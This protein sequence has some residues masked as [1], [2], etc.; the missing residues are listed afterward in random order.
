ME[1]II[2]HCGLIGG[3]TGRNFVQQPANLW[4]PWVGKADRERTVTE[5]T[6]YKMPIGG[7][8]DT[9]YCKSPQITHPV[10]L[11]WPKSR[12]F[13]YLYQDA[14]MLLRNYPV[15]ATICLYEDS[16]SNDD[17]ESVSDNDEEEESVKELNLKRPLSPM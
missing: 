13:D 16:S 3:V 14:E 15:Q 9:K 8:S 4:R 5:N 2:G 11:F 12:C 17:E 1:N 6:P 10:K 7:F